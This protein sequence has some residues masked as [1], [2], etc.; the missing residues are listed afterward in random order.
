MAKTCPRKKKKKKKSRVRKK[1]KEGKIPR[2]KFFIC[3]T[4]H[5]ALKNFSSQAQKFTSK[6]RSIKATSISQARPAK[7]FN[8]K[9][10][11]L[12]RERKNSRIIDKKSK[13]SFTRSKSKIRAAENFKLSG[14]VEII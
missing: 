2:K 13:R 11:N 10:V 6:R 8:E 4:H 9:S 1:S 7:K 5:K 12:Q 14:G 3:C